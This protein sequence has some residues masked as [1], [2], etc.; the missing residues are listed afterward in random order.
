MSIRGGVGPTKASARAEEKEARAAAHR[1]AA[2]A[3][4]P[5][6]RAQ[7]KAEKMQA[8]FAKQEAASQRPLTEAQL[9]AAQKEAA[10]AEEAIKDL[11]DRTM[12]RLSSH[13]PMTVADEKIYKYVFDAT[14]KDGAGKAVGFKALGHPIRPGGTEYPLTR[15]MYVHG[16]ALKR[17]VIAGA[18]THGAEMTVQDA[19]KLAELGVKFKVTAP[20]TAVG[21]KAGGVK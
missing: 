16:E 2:L 9:V 1:A 18:S 3:Q 11:A 13:M 4:L 8:K 7:E 19:E 14:H 21:A 6:E 12:A 20:L 5:E 17:Q 15:K 10:H